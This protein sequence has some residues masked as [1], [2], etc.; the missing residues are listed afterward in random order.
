MPNQSVADGI[1][2]ISKTGGQTDAF[3]L[4]G[5]FLLNPIVLVLVGFCIGAIVLVLFYVYVWKRD[6]GTTFEIERFEDTVLK[7]LKNTFKTEGKKS[8]SRIIHGIN[9]PIGKVEKWLSHKGEWQVLEYNQTSK[10]YEPKTIVTKVKNDKGKIVSKRKEA[11]IPYD[12]VIFKVSGSGYFE[13]PKFIIA[14]RQF[15]EYDAKGNV[16]Q[17]DKDVALKSFGNA[18]ITSEVGQKYLQD[19]SFRRSLEN[20]MTFLQNQSRKVIF[21]E[22]AFAQKH[23]L[24]LGKGL[25]KRLQY[26]QYAKDVLVKAGDVGEAEDET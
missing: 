25:S 4:I 24:L 3:A 2:A 5:S 6:E 10:E 23:E 21:L 22:T 9:N 11:K 1:N 14:D 12:F 26:D 13:E 7:D 17:I 16:W 8:N 15:V 20:N 18:W 19:I